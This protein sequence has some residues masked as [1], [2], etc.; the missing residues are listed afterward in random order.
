MAEHGTPPKRNPIGI[1]AG[2]GVLPDE[3]AKALTKNNTPFF[4]ATIK[5]E[6]TASFSPTIS[7]AFTWGEIGKILK[8]FKTVHVD[9]WRCWNHEAVAQNC[10]GDDRW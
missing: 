2:G 4:V 3:L 5:D 1:V 8:Y 7:S 9:H 10:D 6:T